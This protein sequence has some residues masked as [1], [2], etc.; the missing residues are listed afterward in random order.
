MCQ[1]QWKEKVMI[2]RYLMIL[3]FILIFPKQPKVQAIPFT[4]WL[5]PQIMPPGGQLTKGMKAQ[6]HSVS[7][8][9]VRGDK[10]KKLIYLSRLFLVFTTSPEI[11]NLGKKW[12]TEGIYATNL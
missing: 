11:S 8:I 6:Y 5:I 7:E 1:I 12:K 4:R 9:R 2:N 3:P 10:L